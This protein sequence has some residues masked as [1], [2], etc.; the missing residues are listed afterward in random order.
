MASMRGLK[1]HEDGILMD[2]CIHTMQLI[3]V[4]IQTLNAL[5]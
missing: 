1:Q 3:L 2:K 4:N 5:A